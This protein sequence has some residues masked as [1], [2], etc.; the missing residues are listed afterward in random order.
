M[1]IKEMHV[2]VDREHYVQAGL[3][4]GYE[5]EYRALTLLLRWTRLVRNCAYQLYQR[6]LRH[7]VVWTRRRGGGK[8]LSFRFHGGVKCSQACWS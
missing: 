1:T 6:E 4:P 7:E 2:I 5:H 8:L 3:L